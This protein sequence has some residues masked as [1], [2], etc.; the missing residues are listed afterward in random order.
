ME[1]TICLESIDER[2]GSATLSCGH[3]YHFG[4]LAR[5]ILKTQ[6]CPYCRHET[7]AFETIRQDEEADAESEHESTVISEDPSL[8]WVRIGPGHWR[9][10]PRLIQQIPEFNEENHALWVF[11]SFFHQLEEVDPK[12]ASEKQDHHIPYI[13]LLTRHENTFDAGN[14]RGYDSA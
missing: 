2:T 9:T 11:R 8:R 1:C 14:D 5:W 12:P 4:C 3:I 7:N 10:F 13:D 6:S